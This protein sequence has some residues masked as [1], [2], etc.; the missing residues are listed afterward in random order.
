MNE[1]ILSAGAGFLSSVTYA[2]F[3]VPN[4][5]FISNEQFI[6][7]IVLGFVGGG[8]GWLAKELCKHVMYQYKR[9]RGKV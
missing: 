9:L 3:K 7:V 1:D 8:A 2:L 5:E 4:M 6:S